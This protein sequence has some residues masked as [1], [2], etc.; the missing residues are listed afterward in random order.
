M[1]EITTDK[2]AE[3]LDVIKNKKNNKDT[4]KILRI[5]FIN[6]PIFITLYIIIS[7]T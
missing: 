2:L 5:I 6:I 4:K 3:G 7:I 1:L